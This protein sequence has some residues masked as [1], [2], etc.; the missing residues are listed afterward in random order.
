MEE[1]LVAAR[2]RQLG[3]EAVRGKEDLFGFFFLGFRRGTAA[4]GVE[5][6]QRERKGKEEEKESLGGS[7]RR[8]FFLSGNQ[9]GGG[10]EKEGIQ[11]QKKKVLEDEDTLLKEKLSGVW[12]PRCTRPRPRRRLASGVHRRRTRP[13]LRRRC[14]RPNTPPLHS[15]MMPPLH[16]S[17]TPPL[18][19][20]RTT[21]P[22]LLRFSLR[23][24]CPGQRHHCHSSQPRRRLRLEGR[25]P[26]LSSRHQGSGAV[27]PAWRIHA[28]VLVAAAAARRWLQM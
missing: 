3:G 18:H 26:E 17:K 23:C 21:P 1:L 4:G 15:S 10:E 27:H 7:S 11:N 5:E 24:H 16:S 8:F 28:S 6:W 22:P 2:E 9:K 14:T 20:S 25:D 12:R 19:S 13:R